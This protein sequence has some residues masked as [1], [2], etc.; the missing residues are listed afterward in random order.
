MTFKPK[1]K[2]ISDVYYRLQSS[3]PLTGGHREH[4]GEEWKVLESYIKKYYT[5]NEFGKKCLK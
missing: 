4:L 3:L 1:N 2:L 5:V